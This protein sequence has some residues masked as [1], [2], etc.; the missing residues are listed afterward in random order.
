LRLGAR[1][2]SWGGVRTCLAAV[3][4]L[5]AMTSVASAECPMSVEDLPPANFFDAQVATVMGPVEAAPQGVAYDAAA[6]LGAA[7][8]T[9]GAFAAGAASGQVQARHG[10]VQGCASAD[11]RFA[12]EPSARVTASAQVPMLMS[13][14]VLGLAVD[15]DVEVA[16]SSRPEY[17]RAPID[18]AMFQVG[19]AF[20]DFQTRDPG[21]DNVLRI[22]AM[23]VSVATTASA[24]TIEDA[25]TDTG[26]KRVTTE[27]GTAMFRILAQ[28]AHS[29]GTF[30]VFRIAVTEIANARTRDDGHQPIGFLRLDILGFD[31]RSPRWHLA[32]SGGFLVDEA[33][34]PE[35][36][37]GDANAAGDDVDLGVG[38]YDLAF[39][40]AWKSAWL[41]T[42]LV[43]S[44]FL[45]ADDTIA[46]EDRASSGITLSR[47]RHR[48]T[49]TAFSARTRAYDGGPA[50]ST[51]GGRLVVSQDL[52]HH[53]AATVDAEV[54]RG[55]YGASDGG[56]PEVTTSARVLAHLD[57][58]VGRRAMN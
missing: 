26:T 9:E 18:R 31:Y 28:D 2:A 46:I 25:T 54:A 41:E 30:D 3:T 36:A 50:A 7:A 39:A 21:T 14:L 57:W 53:L 13:S 11:V 20:L 48:G 19:F 52:D 56:A 24:Q 33:D 51:G 35:H 4:T 55:F 45:A 8:D 17:A 12:R 32:A 27:I 1:L 44:G 6:S 22:Q 37:S 47:V 29:N 10:A 5:A 42:R 34:A 40:H 58:H 43:R 38:A 15:R 23:P 16:L 49:L